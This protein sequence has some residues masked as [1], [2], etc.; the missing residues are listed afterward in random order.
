MG[1]KALFPKFQSERSFLHQTTTIKLSRKFK[2]NHVKSFA[3]S[4]CTKNNCS[5]SNFKFGVSLYANSINKSH[6]ENSL[7]S[8]KKDKM[9]LPTQRSFYFLIRAL[10]RTYQELCQVDESAHLPV[11]SSSNSEKNTISTK[12]KGP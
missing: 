11:Q 4:Q 8:R 6:F 9:F 5:N 7:P 12:K 3:I 10:L 1:L 2:Q